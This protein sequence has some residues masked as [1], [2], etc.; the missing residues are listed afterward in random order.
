[1]TEIEWDDHGRPARVVTR[2]EPE[3]DDEQVDLL[4]AGRQLAAEVGPHG[5]PM[6]RATD[7]AGQPFNRRKPPGGFH[8][9]ARLAATD[10]AQAA[11]DEAQ[12]E[13]YKDESRQ[14]TRSADIWIVEEKP[15]PTIPRP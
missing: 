8:W 12:R 2:R 15:D 6:V 4:L 11:L 9:S 7:P 10:W 3:F 1:M 13:H 5:Q 14:A